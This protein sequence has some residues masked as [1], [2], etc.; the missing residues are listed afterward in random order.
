MQ[1]QWEDPS[2]V[3]D[4]S[5]DDCRLEFRWWEFLC[6]SCLKLNKNNISIINYAW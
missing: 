4:R 5:V 1:Y 6:T 2:L 3:R